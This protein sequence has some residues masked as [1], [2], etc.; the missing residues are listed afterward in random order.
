M[1][2]CVATPFADSLSPAAASAGLGAA[3]IADGHL[4]SFSKQE[5]LG[6]IAAY[7]LCNPAAFAGLPAA[8]IADGDLPWST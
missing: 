8:I 5:V 4:P 6:A 2:V 1:H 7:S 3:V